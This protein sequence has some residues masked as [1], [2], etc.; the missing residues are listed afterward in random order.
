MSPDIIFIFHIIGIRLLNMKMKIIIYMLFSVIQ[1]ILLTLVLYIE[2][3]YKSKK[4]GF[5]TE[6]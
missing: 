4:K 3:P 5:S 6:F 1:A 2:M